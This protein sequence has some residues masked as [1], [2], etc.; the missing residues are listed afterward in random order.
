MPGPKPRLH[1]PYVAWPATDRLLWERGLGH[2]DPFADIHLAKASRDRCMWS[3][4]RFLGFLA[5]NEPGALEI[6]PAQRL[7]IGRVKLLV[8][9]LAETNAPNSVAAVIEGL[10]TAARVMMPDRDWSWLKKIKS[11]LQAV[12]PARSPA[13]PVITSVQLLELGLKLMDETA[14]EPGTKIDVHQ[15][16]AYRDG[17]ILSVLAY[18]PLRPKNLVSLEMG[19]HLFVDRDRWFIVVPREETKTKKRIQFEIPKLLLPYLTVYLEAVRPAILRGRTHTALWVSASGGALSYVGVVKSFARLS[20]SLG[21]R[22]SPHDARDAAVTT[23]AIARPDQIC[24][25]RDLLYHSRLDTTNLYNRA[26]GIEA[27]RAYRQMIRG[28][29]NEPRIRGKQKRAV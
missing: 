22:I 18:G 6:A 13:G 21:V 7:T 15:G 25:S 24:V 5:D 23:W 26:T 1:L 14:I 29:R 19:R 10:Y 16:V 4:R 17:L 9:H 20:E 28:I 3:W 27:S 12:V 8:A 11:R 2:E